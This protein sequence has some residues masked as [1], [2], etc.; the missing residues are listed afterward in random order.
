MASPNYTPPRPLR[1]T[2]K[3]ISEFAEQVANH[4]GYVAGSSMH[5]L[6]TQLNGRISY[7]D[8]AGPADE[9]PEAIVVS[10]GGSFHIFLPS[11][12]SPERDRFTIAHEL[13]HLFLHFPAISKKSPT[14][15]MKATRWVDENNEPQRRAEWEANWFAA[16]FLMPKAEFTEFYSKGRIRAATHFGVS[17]RA[18]EV[19]AESLGI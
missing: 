19:R 7:Q 3:A 13:G 2:K 10:P 12:T 4:I 18:A 17:V 9:S 15:Y 14:A 1:A 11:V 6:V 8:G 16:S 5:S